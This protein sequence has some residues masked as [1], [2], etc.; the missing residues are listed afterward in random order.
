MSRPFAGTGDR[1]LLANTVGTA[2]TYD[3]ILMGI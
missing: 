1:L 3:I 2:V